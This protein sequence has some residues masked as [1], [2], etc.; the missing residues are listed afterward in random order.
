MK[1]RRERQR[2]FEVGECFHGVKIERLLSG[3]PQE[4]ERGICPIAAMLPVGV[5]AA[6]WV[7]KQRGA[8]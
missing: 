6:V 8:R 1:L 4:S 5:A 2:T 3:E 7:R